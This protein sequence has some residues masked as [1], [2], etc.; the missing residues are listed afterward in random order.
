MFKKYMKMLVCIVAFASALTV[1]ASAYAQDIGDQDL[2]SFVTGMGIMNGYPDGSFG[3]DN[4]VSR[5]E[6]AKVAVASSKYKNLTAGQVTVSPFSDVPFHHWAAPYVRVASVNGYITGY[7]DATFKPDNAVLCEEAVT[8]AL[9]ML[10][11]TNSDF[12]TAWP[13]GQMSIAAELDLTDGINAS[14]GEYMTRRDVAQLMYNLMGAKMKNTNG[15]YASEINCE[16]IKDVILMSCEV[17]DA[18]KG[19][20]KIVTSTGTYKSDKAINSNLIGRN[21][22]VIIKNGDKAAAFVSYGQSVNV[23]V[24]YSHLDG[25]V[26]TYKDGKLSQISVDNTATA[27]FNGSKTTF[28]SVKSNLA[29]GDVIYV[30]TNS[31]GS[32][33]YV[34]VE[35]GNLQGPYTVRSTQWYNAFNG[36]ENAAVMR[37][38]VKVSSSDIKMYDVVYYSADLNIIFAYSKKVTGI[39]QSASPNSD[40]PETITVSGTTYKLESAAA[41]NAVS[42]SGSFIPGDTV[43]ILIGRSGD[44]ADV[45]DPDA[46]NESV[47]GYLTQTGSK[48]FTNLN[49]EKYTSN[50]IMV[51][52]ADGTENEYITGTGYS[53]NLGDVV[54]VSFKNGVATV[55]GLTSPGG[56]YGKVSSQDRKIG[57]TSVSE[58]VKIIDVSKGEE[59]EATAWASV[60]LQRIDGVD[61]KEKNVLYYTKNSSGQ[62]TSLILN[63]VTGDAYKYGIVTDAQTSNKGMSVSGR[64]TVD[65]AGKTYSH[66]LSAVY[67][68]ISSGY[69]V[70]V[71]INGGSIQ[72]I[73]ALPSLSGSITDI[74]AATVETVNTEYEISPDVVVYKRNSDYQYM[75]VP[76][77]DA[78]SHSK[79]SMTVFFDRSPADGG[80]VRIIVL[81]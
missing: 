21:G 3:L 29:M 31:S 60:F 4:N 33:E 16:F 32:I 34:T 58:S 67:N 1:S 81:K 50:Y 76:L 27:Y 69:P 61:L 40:S 78:L 7:V 13:Y 12:G 2:I 56:L 47:I 46:S 42:S 11:Y 28:G 49:G 37:D 18:A 55:S 75:V 68:G 65:I 57:S 15:N 53:K 45:V 73:A 80:Q 59:G 14:I 62:I 8:V 71:A 36:A 30:K 54:K 70:K 17:D 72:S 19:T 10:G 20:Y 63:D 6:F 5:G 38:G 23:Y 24:V 48:E 43:T 44:V 51:A 35:K 52:L 26:V 25:A 9:K 22:S 77:T 79:G 41:F 39:Y 66:N 64:Y 74:S